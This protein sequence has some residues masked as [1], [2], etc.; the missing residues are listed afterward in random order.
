MLR[1]VCDDVEDDIVKIGWQIADGKTSATISHEDTRVVVRNHENLHGFY[2]LCCS[3][4]RGYRFN[5]RKNN[6]PKSVFFVRD[7]PSRNSREIASSTLAKI[8][9]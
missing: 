8:K 6:E 4:P 2:I 1:R 5:I 7:V 3:L 9:T